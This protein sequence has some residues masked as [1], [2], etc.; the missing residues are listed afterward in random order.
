MSASNRPKALLAVDAENHTDLD[1]AALLKRLA[2]VDIVERH[3]YADLRNPYLRGLLTRLRCAGFLIHHA[4]SGDRPG[5]IK[6]TADGHMACGIR[7]VLAA[8]PEIETVVIVSGDNFFA[9]IARELADAGKNV[10]VASNPGRI[11]KDL[12][13]AAHRYIPLGNLAHQ[14]AQ[15]DGLERRNRYL[16]F[17]FARRRTGIAAEDLDRLIDHGLVIRERVRHPQRGFQTEIH[18][19]RQS[20]VVQAALAASAAQL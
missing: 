18:L 11:G 8:H 19:N 5:E 10:I 7:D 17:G 20:Y 14:I 9:A 4:P 1:V 13:A 12:R 2:D 16:T 6:N 3:A 15:L